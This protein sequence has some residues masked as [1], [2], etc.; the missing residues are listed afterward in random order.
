MSVF[1]GSIDEAG[2]IAANGLDVGRTP[3]WASRDLHAAANAIGPK[4]LEY[5][6]RDPGIIESQ[7]PKAEFD[8]VLGASERPYGGWF[9]S[10]LDSTEIVLRTPEQVE[11]FN[12]YIT[13]RI[14]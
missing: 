5:P 14:Q 11:L 10:N 8:A 7:I 12:R 1:H 13:G 6:G 2:T 3:T 9:G 4:R